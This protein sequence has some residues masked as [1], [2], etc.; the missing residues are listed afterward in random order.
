MTDRI[1]LA[2]CSTVISS[3]CR[4][5]LAT[6]IGFV[7]VVHAAPAMPPLTRCIAVGWRYKGAVP[8]GEGSRMREEFRA[9]PLLRVKVK[10]QPKTPYVR[11]FVERVQRLYCEVH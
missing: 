7:A 11:V 9:A 1:S 5:V 2:S 8:D 10:S 3:V 4:R 6:S